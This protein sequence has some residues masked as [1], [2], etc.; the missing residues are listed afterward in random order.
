VSS[1]LQAPDLPELEPTEL[2]GAARGGAVE[3]RQALVRARPPGAEPVRAQ[4]A[5]IRESELHGVVLEAGG[6]PGLELIDVVLRDCGL[7]N[8][9]ARE[10]VLRR[11]EAHR[12]RLVWFGISNG[13]VQHLRIVDSSLQLASFAWA[14]LR[15][16]VFERVN[17]TDSSFMGARLEDV[18]FIDCTLGGADFRQAAIRGAAIRGASLTGVLGIESMAGLRMEWTDV[19]ASAAELAAALGITVLDD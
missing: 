1:A 8:V 12:C 10:G 3:L 18:E 4:Q 13:D 14:R 2:A 9:D 16:V 17:L 5:R 15:H 19:L 6:S 7:S 11:V